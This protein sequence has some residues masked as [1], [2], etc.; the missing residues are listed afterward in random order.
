MKKGRFEKLEVK[1]G[2]DTDK[3]SEREVK[4]NCP[5]CGSLYRLNDNFCSNCGGNLSRINKKH[6]DAQPEREKPERK[7]ESNSE[8]EP[9]S[10]KVDKTFLPKETIRERFKIE[11]KYNIL[12]IIIVSLFLV[13]AFLKPQIFD[14][15]SYFNVGT[16]KA[17]DIR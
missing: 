5:A 17:S 6:A 11:N 4:L 16:K 14:I 10:K 8:K 13:L 12:Y 1:Q 9:P 2:V 3:K 15:K 7:I